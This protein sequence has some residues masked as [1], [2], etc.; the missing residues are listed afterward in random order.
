MMNIILS[1]FPFFIFWQVFFVSNSAQNFAKNGELSDTLYLNIEEID[2]LHT[3]ASPLWGHHLPKLGIMKNNG[4]QY[5]AK[6]SGSYPNSEIE[7]MEK[8]K[9]S[10]W[11]SIL[12]L[13]NTYQP[14][15]LL[16]DENE[17]IHIIH[18]SQTE[19]IVQLKVDVLH[20]PI[21]VDTVSVGNGQQDGRGWY[22]GA[23]LIGKKIF[24]AYIT[25]SYDLFLTW[26]NIND[27]HW[28]TP[29]L[30]H[31]G[32]V[33][34][35]LGNH[36]WTRPKFDF[37]KNNG[38]FVVNETSDGSVKNTYN[39]IVM[40]TFPI[41]NPSQFVTEYVDAVPL[42]YTAFSTDFS[43]SPA[44]ML[45]CTYNKGKQIYDT[46]KN[47]T[48][49]V[50]GTYTAIKNSNEKNWKINRVFDSPTEGCV[51][52]GRDN[53]ICVFQIHEKINNSKTHSSSRWSALLTNDNG[54]HWDEV[55][56]KTNDS[57]YILPSHLQIL[58]ENIKTL[59]HGYGLFEDHISTEKNNNMRFYRLYA[60][61]AELVSV[62]KY[63]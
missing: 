10:S 40:V 63:K 22:L 5:V 59:N 19:P 16:I 2:T 45:V 52:Y 60:F 41:T 48:P 29:V 57:E 56:V 25:L 54:K 6:Y 13:S 26:K 9:H 27:K 8:R 34:A 17:M 1:L 39:A 7:I 42:G 58:S 55:F 62:H 12:S 32:K 14:G 21:H 43:I 44:G 49:S 24:M 38:Y 61:N 18:N 4:T 20:T 47:I 28:K 33:D 46:G 31:K 53:T 23:G 3:W 50:P 15:I 51:L 35:Q 30:I 37:W 36:T 11:K